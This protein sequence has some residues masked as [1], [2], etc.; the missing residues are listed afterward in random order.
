M[1]GYLTS[2]NKN[3]CFGCGACKQVCPKNA[4]KMQMDFEGFLYPN[5]SNHLCIKCGLCHK[6]CPAENLPKAEI[7]QQALL[8]F[9]KEQTV[10]MNSASGG[11]FKAIID[12]IDS[13]S[14]VFGAEWDSRSSVSHDS[15]NTDIAYHRFHK[16]KYIQSDL[17]NSYNE[18]KKYLLNGDFVLFSATPCQ[19][20]G[21]KS[22]LGRN[23]KICCA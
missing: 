12:S 17:K 2:N 7:P 16:S 10:R 23:I 13:N 6:A 4:I 9:N 15:A 19:I 18:A 22:F 11:A 5:V 1:I 14:I 8:G 21:L 3:E 20:A